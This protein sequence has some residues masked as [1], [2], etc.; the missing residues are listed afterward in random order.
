MGGAERAKTLLRGVCALI[1]VS[2]CVTDTVP[3]DNADKL[4]QRSRERIIIIIL[5]LITV[6]PFMISLTLYLNSVAGHTLINQ[7][8]HAYF[9]TCKIHTKTPNNK[10]FEMHPGT[11]EVQENFDSPGI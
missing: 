1:L 5:Y 2:A 4:K 3:R 8:K 9:G 7:P 10:H 11:G 6:W